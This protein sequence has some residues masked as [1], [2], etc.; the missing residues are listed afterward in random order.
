MAWRGEMKNTFTVDDQFKL[1]DG[2]K[3]EFPDFKVSVTKSYTYHLRAAPVTYGD[4]SIIKGDNIHINLTL[5][6][7]LFDREYHEIVKKI[8]Y[9][10]DNCVNFASYGYK[11]RA[12]I[13]MPH[14]PRYT[15]R[16]PRDIIVMTNSPHRIVG[17]YNSL[18]SIYPFKVYCKEPGSSSYTLIRPKNKIFRTFQDAH[19]ETSKVEEF[20][21]SHKEAPDP[22]GFKPVS[23][24]HH[25]SGWVEIDSQI[26][27]I[28]VVQIGSI[29]DGEFK[30]DPDCRQ[31]EA[32]YIMRL[33]LHS[34]HSTYIATDGNVWHPVQGK[35][36]FRLT[37]MC[38]HDDRLSKM[39]EHD[40]DLI[41]STIDEL[42]GYIID[43]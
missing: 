23:Y 41:K 27:S 40:K 18:N 6:K 9:I 24:T 19:A 29:V 1:P 31:G 7:S 8:R 13:S 17:T 25:K 42:I 33:R 10:V 36:R 39:N 2:F 28:G 22:R 20:V 3:D 32:W 16:P 11:V 34:G 26:H 15:T 4:M 38:R 30:F 43:E 37:Q 14:P 21:H 35:K 5:S 12:A